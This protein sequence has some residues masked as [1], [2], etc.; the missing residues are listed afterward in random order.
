MKMKIGAASAKHF[1][2]WV[3]ADGDHFLDDLDE[4]VFERYEDAVK[5]LPTP[6]EEALHGVASILVM[7]TVLYMTTSLAEMTGGAAK[8]LRERHEAGDI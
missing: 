2:A 8:G 5:D 3:R 1:L 6:A 7:A 4:E